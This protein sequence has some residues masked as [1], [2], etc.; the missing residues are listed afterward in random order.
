MEWDGDTEIPLSNQFPSFHLMEIIVDSSILWNRQGS[1]QREWIFVSD[2]KKQSS[3]IKVH[4]FDNNPTYLRVKR[5]TRW[6]KKYISDISLQNFAWN[7]PRMCFVFHVQ[8]QA[9]WIL[10]P[11]NTHDALHDANA[12]LLW[13][14]W[15]YFSDFDGFIL[16]QY[17]T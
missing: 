8:Q 6:K 9:G 15:I 16:F 7:L 11:I 1:K 5:G 14:W 2:L 13:F 12:L 4:Q 17:R 10:A 3:L